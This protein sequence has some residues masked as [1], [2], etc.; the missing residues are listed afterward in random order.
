MEVKKCSESVPVCELPMQE[1]VNKYNGQVYLK[2][3]ICG[4]IE[5][6][7]LLETPF[8]DNR[9]EYEKKPPTDKEGG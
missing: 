8:Y 9:E 5:E 1:K 2:C 7:G 6:T 3:P 4:H